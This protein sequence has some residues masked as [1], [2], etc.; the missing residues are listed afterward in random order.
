MM[1]RGDEGGHCSWSYRCPMP[2][3]ASQRLPDSGGRLC[4]VFCFVSFSLAWGWL[5]GWMGPCRDWTERRGWGDSVRRGCSRP[6]AGMAGSSQCWQAVVPGPQGNGCKR[7]GNHWKCEERSVRNSP[8]ST[9][10]GE[11]RTGR[12]LV[13]DV[14]VFTSTYKLFLVVLS[15][16]RWGGAVRE[17]LGG[18]QPRS[19]TR[20]ANLGEEE[21]I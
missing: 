16:S 12:W 13:S 6:R 11:K 7:R 3:M 8:V 14:P 10:P 17:W 9:E 1:A 15:P 5:V 4:V 20:K 2:P 19:I 18:G 21:T